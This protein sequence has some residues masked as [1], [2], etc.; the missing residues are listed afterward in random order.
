M[1]LLA[2]ISSRWYGYEA[3]IPEALLDEAA[4]RFALLG[5][6]SRLRILSTLHEA[7]EVPV[8]EL[9]TSAG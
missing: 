4:H 1:S 5:D 8:G 6:P 9:A 7:G 3:L 2:H